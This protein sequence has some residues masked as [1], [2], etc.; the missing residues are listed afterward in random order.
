MAI[1]RGPTPAYQHVVARGLPYDRGHAH[2]Q[3]AAE[4]VKANVEYYKKPGKL[5]KL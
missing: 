3:Q 5:A 4:K 1:S 2:G